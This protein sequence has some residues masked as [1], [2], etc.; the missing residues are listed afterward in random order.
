MQ[1]LADGAVQQHGHDRGVN[2][3]GKGADHVLVA[4]LI[5]HFLDHAF[6]KG[7]HGPVGLDA[8]NLE[9]EVLEHAFAVHA[10]VHFGV[11]LHSVDFALFISHGSDFERAGAGRDSEAGRRHHNLVAV[12]HP[13]AGGRSDAVHQ[14]AGRNEVEVGR[15]VFPREGLGQLPAKVLG[16]QLHA[17]ADAEHGHAQFQKTGIQR[18]S[19]GFAHAG[20][21]AGQN[22]GLG[23]HGG[24]LFGGGHTGVDFRIHP[25]FAHAPRDKLGNLRAVIYDNDLAGHNFLMICARPAGGAPVPYV[26]GACG[27]AAPPA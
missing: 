24:H 3:A 7:R 25:G 21:A 23:L 11:E 2:A 13:Y 19:V 18:R 17:I 1:A 10:V 20:R 9:Q 8:D 12:A 4:G 22:D 6:H 16:Q 15:A 27:I 26:Q 5:G 14:G